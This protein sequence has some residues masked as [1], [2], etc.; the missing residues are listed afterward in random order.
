MY[1]SGS[2]FPQETLKGIEMLLPSS[3][4]Q[5]P[6]AVPG[7][8]GSGS[9]CTTFRD[10]LSSLQFRWLERVMYMSSHYPHPLLP[11]LLPNSGMNI[12]NILCAL[13]L[14]TIRHWGWDQ[15]QYSHS[16]REWSAGLPFL[17]P[18][19]YLIHP[20][21]RRSEPEI[22]ALANAGVSGN[23]HASSG[24]HTLPLDIW[25]WAELFIINCR[26]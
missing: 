8:M 18:D 15:L 22:G 24:T 9:H 12:Q 5:P 26:W 23:G 16:S 7:L 1:T 11:D 19:T 17:P 6:G 20:P 25:G 3:H 14:F 13:E 21:P 4:L 10:P 2:S